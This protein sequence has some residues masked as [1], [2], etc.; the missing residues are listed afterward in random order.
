M[1]SVQL[2]NLLLVARGLTTNTTRLLARRRSRR[3]NFAHAFWFG[4]QPCT[5]LTLTP[6]KFT[7]PTFAKALKPNLPD[8]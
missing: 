7:F 1:V 6:M 3:A 8:F 2:F 5:R 4:G